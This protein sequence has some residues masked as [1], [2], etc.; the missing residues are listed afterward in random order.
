MKNPICPD[1]GK[2]VEKPEDAATG[3]EAE[4]MREGKAPKYVLHKKHTGG[5]MTTV[6]SSKSRPPLLEELERNMR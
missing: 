5:G 3:I 1:C 2:A 4:A 6:C